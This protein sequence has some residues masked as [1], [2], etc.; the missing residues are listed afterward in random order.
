MEKQIL[1]ERISAEHN[2]SNQSQFEK[3]VYHGLKSSP[4]T[5]KSKY[6]YD[7]TGDEIF[8]E[9]M[10]LPEYYITNCEYEILKNNK[11]KIYS[12]LE[13]LAPFQLI[14]LGAGD[15]RKTQVLLNF[16]VSQKLNFT[17]VPV[18]IS[19]N[20]IHQVTSR[21]KIDCP[22]LN[23]AGISEEFLGALNLLDN[24]R[25]VILFLGSSIGNFNQNETI[26][27][28]KSIAAR[29]NKDDLLMI[30][31]DLKK[32]PEVILAAYND[33][34]GVTAKFNL[35]LLQRINRELGADFNLK[36]FKHSPTYHKEEGEARST[37]ESLENQEIYIRNLKLNIHLEKG[38]K[39]HTEVSR[40]FDLKEIQDIAAA[41]GFEVLENLMDS[42]NYFTN[43]IWHRKK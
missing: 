20:A 34:K 7:S 18:D 38:E 26:K 36:L 12:Q 8:Q 4:K 3:D 10:K 16:F 43:S 14:D 13:S 30:G 42:R 32:D 24:Q 6:F 21:L 15:A 23:V 2:Q 22:Y 33:K 17:Y 37:L 35:N 29:I 9:I 41:S 19:A 27:F 25:K 39:I 28:F 40:K 31:F 1:K 5:L 11:E